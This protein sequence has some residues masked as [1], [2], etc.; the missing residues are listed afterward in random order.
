MNKES[1]E[2][3]RHQIV[4]DDIKNKFRLT[5]PDVVYKSFYR[6]NSFRNPIAATDVVYASSALAELCGQGTP[7]SKK[8]AFNDAYDCMGMNDDIFKRGKEIAIDLQKTIVRKAQ[9]ILEGKDLI[10][11]MSNFYYAY[12]HT[13][14]DTIGPS[15]DGN[16]SSTFSRPEVLTRLGH[17]IT[18][19]KCNMEKGVGGWVKKPL[20]LIIASKSKDGYIVVGVSPL[21]YEKSI[22][23]LKMRER[24]DNRG[25][26]SEETT[27]QNLCK[28]NLIFKSAASLSLSEGDYRCNS[29]DSN[30]FEVADINSF[31]GAL[32]LFYSSLVR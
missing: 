16:D 21:S 29:F 15:A 7:D 3:F 6:Y 20:P 13:S 25:N 9:A 12:V 27:L 2:H 19:V 18:E 32:S 5:G 8:E 10:T 31:I 22:A 17:Y 30:I 11:K 4:K 24:D 14:V 23:I 26:N 1:K 28:F